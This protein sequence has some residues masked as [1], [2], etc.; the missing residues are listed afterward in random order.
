MFTP[1]FS[2]E[3]QEEG[4]FVAFSREFEGA[5]GQGETIEEALKDLEEAIQLLGEVLKEDKALK[6]ERNR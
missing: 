2:L 3:P 4:G 6:E 5:V 1:R